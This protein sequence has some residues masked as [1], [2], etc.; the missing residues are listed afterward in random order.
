MTADPLDVM[1]LPIVGVEPRPQFEASLLRRLKRE[2]GG[3]AGRGATVRYFVDDI[4]SAIHFYCQ[5]LDFEAELSRPPA[6]AMLYRGDLRLLLS[7]PGAHVLSDG[8][9]P[10]PGGWN[11]I[12]L[13][14]PDLDAAVAELRSQGVAL[15]SDIVSGV[16]VNQILVQDPAGNLIELFETVSGYHERAAEPA[17]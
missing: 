13:Q 16:G 7:A 14:V 11:R 15:R 8:S 10:E 6:F 1:R 12:S 3:P 9:R 2:Q 5:Q 4:E 17:T